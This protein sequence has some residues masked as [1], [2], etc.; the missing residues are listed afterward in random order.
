MI[1][2]VSDIEQM[3]SVVVRDL[4]STGKLNFVEVNLL[5]IAA[6][7]KISQHMSV[8]PANSHPFS[9]NRNYNP[10]I[11]IGSLVR[12][13]AEHLDK[14]IEYAEEGPT[15]RLMKYCLAMEYPASLKELTIQ[16]GNNF[17]DKKVPDLFI[18]VTDSIDPDLQYIID[19]INNNSINPFLGMRVIV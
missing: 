2:S 8:N 15:D 11:D 17:P 18:E 9:Y 7:F 5:V 19:F 4:K 6:I 3:L 1:T 16:V 13:T 14:F 10:G 12:R